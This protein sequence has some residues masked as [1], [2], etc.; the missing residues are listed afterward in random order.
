MKMALFTHLIQ[1][2]Q[3]FV[4]GLE[5]KFAFQSLKVSFMI[6]PLLIHANPS[7]PFILETNILN[8]TL[9]VILSQLGIN[10]H[11]H[12]VDFYSCT[13]F[14]FKINFLL[15]CMPLRNDII[16]SKEHNMKSLCILIT[17]IDKISW[18][19]VFWI[20]AKLNGHYLCLD[21]ICHHILS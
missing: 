13:F 11:L 3:T 20:D 7:R 8:F 1:K 16:Y 12:L 2:D 6:A 15:S 17:K 10:N 18:L 14:P 4:C 19:L 21:L 9:G 5:A